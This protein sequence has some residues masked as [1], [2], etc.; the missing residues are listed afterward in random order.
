MMTKEESTNIVNSMTLG[1]GVLMLGHNHIH[2][3]HYNENALSSIFQNAAHVLRDYIMLF[4][5]AIVAFYL[6]YDAA[7]DMQI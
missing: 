6:F 5:Y 2:I 3:S 7:V 4:S 1:T